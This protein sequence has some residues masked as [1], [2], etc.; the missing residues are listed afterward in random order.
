MSGETVLYLLIGGS[1]Y[2]AVVFQI[3]RSGSRADDLVALMQKQ[4]KLTAKI[5]KYNNV[6]VEEIEEVMG[7][8]HKKN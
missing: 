4:V 8:V 6:P 7:I 5:A 3:I 1:I 2:L